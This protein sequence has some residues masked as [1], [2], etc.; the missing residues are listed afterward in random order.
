MSVVVAALRVLA[1]DRLVV[2]YSVPAILLTSLACCTNDVC[3]FIPAVQVAL[4]VSA[5]ASRPTPLLSAGPAVP[6]AS[7]VAAI[8]NAVFTGRYLLQEPKKPNSVKTPKGM[9]TVKQAFSRMEK[10]P[11]G[12]LKL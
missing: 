8:G 9:D 4:L 1:A 12:L 11:R 10:T 5:V 7:N 6:L 3:F 2:I